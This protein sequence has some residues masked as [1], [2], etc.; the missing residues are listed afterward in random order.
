MPVRVS[1]KNNS[2]F[3]IFHAF[4][5]IFNSLNSKTPVNGLFVDVSKAFN[6][7][8]YAVLLDNLF[9]LDFR[10]NCHSWLSSYLSN[11]FQ[12]VE[13][14]GT[15]SDKHKLSKGIPQGSILRPFLFLHYANDLPSVSPKLH[16]T[17][18]ADDTTVL[19]TDV[20]L[21]TS[22]TVVSNELHIVFERFVSNKLSLNVNKTHFML[23]AT[24]L[25]CSDI[26]LLCHNCVVRKVL[27]TK[28]LG[29]F[30]EDNL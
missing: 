20:S 21:K 26:Y 12:Y 9:M 15:K 28:F 4:N 29:L 14:A 18:F 30:I 11:R 1:Q 19:F 13:I 16:F 2:K 5:F 10:G 24:G 23:F 8:D 17:L 25:C 22:L 7:I 6:S 27:S 3:A